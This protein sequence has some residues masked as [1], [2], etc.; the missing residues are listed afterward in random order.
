MTV[1][2]TIAP[3]PRREWLAVR[4]RMLA[5]IRGVLDPQ[6]K[7]AE[8]DGLIGVGLEGR[9]ADAWPALRSVALAAIEALDSS[10]NRRAP[11][12]EPVGGGADLSYGGLWLGA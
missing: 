1:Q 5:A 4:A 8:T 3:P 11:D 12:D 9:L 2:D 7:L 10:R 6:L